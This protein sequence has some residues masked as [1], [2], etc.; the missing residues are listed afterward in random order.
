MQ[1]IAKQSASGPEAQVSEQGRRLAQQGGLS[2]ES[3]SGEG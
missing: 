3:I 1:D 2:K